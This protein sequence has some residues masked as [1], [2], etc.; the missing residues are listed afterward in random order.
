[1]ET[2]GLSLAGGKGERA[3]GAVDI[4]TTPWRLGAR[5]LDQVLL[6]K[7]Y[8]Q[9]VCIGSMNIMTRY[10]SGGPLGT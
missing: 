7:N 9:V 5:K 10:G 1:M 8:V 6:W 4:C 3:N 2:E